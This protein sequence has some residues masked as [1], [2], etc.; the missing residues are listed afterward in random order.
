MSDPAQWTPDRASSI[1]FTLMA[2]SGKVVDNP[3]AR[4]SGLLIA[5]GLPFLCYVST[6]SGHGHWL[7][8]GEFVAAATDLGISHPPGQPLGT[9]TMALAM[10]LPL[11][12]IAFRVAL[13]CALFA[14]L[15]L[16][17]FYRALDATLRQVGLVWDAVVIPL[18]VG[19]TWLLGASY[20]YWFQ[21]V[22]PE[23][24]A[25]EGAL[26]LVALERL[27]ALE[28][29][30]PHPDVRPLYHASL[31]FGLALSNHHFLAF[32]LLPVAMPTLARVRLYKG[33]R[34]VVV[35]AAC[36]LPGL[37]VYLYLLL[38]AHAEPYLNLGEP[39]DF[40]RFFWVVS[41]RTFQKN[42]GSGVPEP[43]GDRLADVGVAIVE[44]L[45]PLI[46]VTG[47]GGIYV[48]FRRPATRRVAWLWTGTLLSY[49]AARVAL[50]FT[51]NN[52]DA[53]GY[54]LPAFAACAVL[55]TVVPALLLALLGGPNPQKPHWSAVLASVVLASL[56]LYQFHRSTDPAVAG[57][58]AS[59][60]RFTATD[61]FDEEIRR[62][63]PPR[64]VLFAYSP[65]TIFRFWGGEAEDGT[66]PDVLLVPVPLLTY[67]GMVPSL[68][69]HSPELAGVLRA[70]VMRGEL[71]LAELQTLASER[72]VLVERDVRVP[73]ALFE[74][75]APNG[76]HYEVLADGATEGDV[77]EGTRSSE[78]AYAH[79]YRLL[80]GTT[81]HETRARLLWLHY[82]TALYY[83]ALGDRRAALVETRA[84]LAVNP[85]PQQ[86]LGL[87]AALSAPGDGP[88]D[89]RAFVVGD[90]SG[91][92][93]P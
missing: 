89:I 18:C 34:P 12:P 73:I 32:L 5:A 28:L 8:S 48:L 55:A 49:G 20:G 39:K 6:L 57:F 59:L 68:V 60:A 83:A 44:N 31:A 4:W 47:L 65:Q 80:A 3:R 35:A 52:P 82:C 72:P 70:Y 17:A 45:M 41:A 77:R 51:A 93:A 19:T 67:P 33:T 40:A 29:A 46:F 76:I 92:T 54:L 11:G 71:G 42:V 66:R 90:S 69:A 37:S 15:G 24:Y 79:L 43:F 62:S 56:G 86:L 23:V 38:R 21:A 81:D 78:A 10:A 58:D 50:G 9:L 74:T 22:R 64:A 7:D 16:G 13:V 27:V 88:I 2:W 1:L 25:L 85:L 87:E 26:L 36:A 53:L 75:L 61:A 63:L 91:S 30:F 14:A 84:A